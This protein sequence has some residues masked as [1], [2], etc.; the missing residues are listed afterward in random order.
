MRK[1]VFQV[2]TSIDGYFEGPDSEIDWH[3]VDNDFN[4]YAI[5]FL[6]TLDTLVFGRKTYELMA[7]YWPTETAIKNEPLVAEK[8]NN[9]S[10][11]VYSTTLEKVDWKKTKLIKAN[12]ADEVAR[13][14]LRQCKDIAILGSSDLA[15]A[16]IPQGLINEYRIIVNPIFLGKG[17]TLLTGLDERLKLKLVFTKTY[18]SGN[19]LLCYVPVKNEL[20]KSSF[21]GDM[22][23]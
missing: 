11:I 22:I 6:N 7:S 21:I 20:S 1:V 16:L 4:N 19:V 12:I 15:L 8:M 5:D 18:R 13:Q 9:L 2:M 10:K 17:K 3:N 23:N 14:K